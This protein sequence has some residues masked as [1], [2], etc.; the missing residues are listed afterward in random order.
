MAPG[1]PTIEK[2]LD[3][4]ATSLKWPRPL[5]LAAVACLI[6]ANRAEA[7]PTYTITDLGTSLD[8]SWFTNSPNDLP[9]NSPLS[10]QG[11]PTVMPAPPVSSDFAYGNPDF[12]YTESRLST[13]NANGLAAGVNYYGVSGHEGNSVAMYAQLM[14]DG[15]WG[16]AH[17][18]WQG[19]TTYFGALTSDASIVGISNT[20]LIF[21]SGPPFPAG[22]TYYLYDV[23]SGTQTTL[24]DLLKNSPWMTPW[25][26]AIDADG[27]LLVWAQPLGDFNAKWHELLLTPEGLSPPNTVPEPTTFAVFAAL[28]GGILVR[29][30]RK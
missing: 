19:S 22:P 27:R 9:A 23:N 20:G 24:G 17:A 14:P 12:V 21:G 11:V 30:G 18:L 6:L 7:V 28:F 16:N 29:R 2:E 3:V 10:W 25:G 8:T 15:S 26:K 5:M 1:L 4:Y 13:M